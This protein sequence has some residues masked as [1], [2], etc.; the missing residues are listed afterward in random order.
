MNEA[1]I[2]SR[3]PIPIIQPGEEVFWSSEGELTDEEKAELRRKFDEGPPG[4]FLMLEGTHDTD[5]S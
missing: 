1:E 3:N 4:T 2:M 5:P